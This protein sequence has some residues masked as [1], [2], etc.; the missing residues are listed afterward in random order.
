MSSNAFYIICLLILLVIAYATRNRWGWWVKKTMELEVPDQA[1]V[2][3]ASESEATSG[4]DN[5]YQQQEEGYREFHNTPN[6]EVERVEAVTEELKQEERHIVDSL[7]DL[8]VS[9]PE[10][11]AVVKS[12]GRFA[13]FD[14]DDVRA[15][16]KQ[17]ASGVSAAQIAS[18]RGVTERTIKRIV[19]RDSYATV[20]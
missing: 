18:E 14:D 13:K 4:V 16:R 15:I 17:A 3:T 2:K 20:F 10:A 11:I 6:D 7:A 5:F 1:E 19:S 12:G 8:P 9:E